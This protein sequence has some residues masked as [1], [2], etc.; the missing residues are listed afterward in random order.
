MIS[1]SATRATRASPGKTPALR[2]TVKGKFLFLGDEKFYLKGVT[3][4]TFSP[5]SNDE[6]F[7]E[8][9]V[10]A[11]DF[12]LMR[13]NGVNTVR[14]YTAP[15]NWLLD[16]ALKRE[17]RVMVGLPWEQHVAFLDEGLAGDVERRVRREVLRSAGHPAVLCYA[18]GNEIPAPMVRWH[19]KKRVETFLHRLYRTVK[20]VDAE[21]LVTYVNYPTT[22]YLE[23]PFLD[24]VAFN[25]YLETQ[26]QLDAYLAKLQ[27]IAG[28]RPLV[29]AEVGLDSRRNGLGK[30]AEVMDWQV[31]SAFGAGCAGMF[32]FAWTDEWYR[33]GH[34][35]EDWD[36]GLVTREREPKPALKTVQSAFKNV[37]F[38]LQTEWPKISVVV[39]SYNGSRTIRDTL[40]G[41]ERLEY[42]NFEAIV[43]DDGST[44]ATAAIAGEYDVKLISTKNGGLSAA[45]T[46]GL[47]TA[48][49]EIVAY[50]DDDAYPDPHWLYYL[51]HSYAVSEYV[52]V[53]GPNLLPA[54]D[55]PIAECVANAPGGPTHVLLSDTEAEHIPGCNM[56]FRRDALLQIGG[57]DPRYRA[58]GDDVD[59][60]WRVQEEVG[61]IGF[62]PAAVVWHHR[63]SSLQMYWKQQQGYGKAEALLA[64]K[65]PER[66][67]MAGHI[68]WS[69][70]I[71]GRGLTEA[72]KLFPQ[73]VYGG[74][75]GSA[76][77][78]SL[79]ERDATTFASLALMPEWYLL[80]GVLAVLSVLGASWSP[81]L[82]AL[83]LLF[84]AIAM[85]L[86]QAVKSAAN[87]SFSSLG[88]PPDR[89]K[90]LKLRG[91]T[92]ILHLAQPAA[93]LTGRLRHGLTLWRQYAPA[94][95]FPRTQT[96][97]VWQEVWRDPNEWLRRLERGLESR[98]VPTQH[99]PIQ[100]GGDFDRWDL[101][102][103]GGA[104]GD[105]HILMAIEEHGSGKQYARFRITPRA[106]RLALGSAAVL[107]A[108]ALLAAL[109]GAW[110]AAVCLLALALPVSL[111]TYQHCA[112]A[113]GV[114]KDAV[115]RL[116]AALSAESKTDLTL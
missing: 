112:A 80:T 20:S 86:G 102:V 95:A 38:N 16:E 75:W 108:L 29:M 107:V 9:E 55:G 46:V 5:N 65:Y 25:A 104:L 13:E 30:Q 54:E 47:H 15:P 70:R 10:V 106:N 19:G 66:Y 44:D 31:R 40:A 82:I 1:S 99:I 97:T 67:N 60:C 26:K 116:D 21:A 103:R 85:P 45:R 109:S 7:P 79:Y 59:A 110:V 93:R 53:G 42:P 91:L 12:A 81:L 61:K 28:E 96:L 69:G 36:F 27:N 3:Y 84:V 57:F 22:E 2:L 41:L 87:A 8:P 76:P 74:T 24:F 92:A 98:Y 34:E 77:F 14:T 52:G 48:T 105:A 56:S 90:A 23:L 100:R 63:R 58:A 83:P 62:S 18:V 32:V 35:I 71:Y 50:L 64:E 114:A 11:K 51:A 94:Q 115:Y 4:G 43:V 101:A 88:D 113:V 6:L 73:R 39:C 17:L 78:Q 33:G 111:A 49:G 72:L 68:A 37:P 89:R